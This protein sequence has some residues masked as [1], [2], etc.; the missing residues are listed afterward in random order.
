VPKA[1]SQISSHQPYR[2]PARR[3][4][5]RYPRKEDRL[6]SEKPRFLTYPEW[7]QARIEFVYV[8]RLRERRARGPKHSEKRRAQW[9]AYKATEKGAASR[10]TYE[11]SPK[12]RETRARY[13]V[14]LP[15]QDAR[16]KARLNALGAALH[17]RC[18]ALGFT[19]GD[20]R[21]WLDTQLKEAVA[22]YK[23]AAGEQQ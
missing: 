3:G 5:D 4:T 9:R 21:A 1:D 8:E 11:R 10:V 6:F 19:G 22:A 23:Q 2:T 14:S 17:G 15:G 12:A 20:L 16:V 7:L 18:A 13:E